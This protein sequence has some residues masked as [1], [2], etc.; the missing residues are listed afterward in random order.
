MLKGENGMHGILTHESAMQ[1]GIKK[2]LPEY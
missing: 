1:G 2:V